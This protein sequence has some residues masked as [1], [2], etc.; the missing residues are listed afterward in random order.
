MLDV[1]GDDYEGSQDC[2]E[3]DWAVGIA[4]AVLGR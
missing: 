1:Y 2:G 4:F 3:D